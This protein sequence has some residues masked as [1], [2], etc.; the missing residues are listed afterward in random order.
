MSSEILHYNKVSE[1]VEIDGLLNMEDK[2][3]SVCASLS[4]SRKKNPSVLKAEPESEIII[5]L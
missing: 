1:L 2:I 3:L 5:F 4:K